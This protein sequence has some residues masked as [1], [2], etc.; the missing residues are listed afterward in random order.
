MHGWEKRSTIGETLP[1]PRG[2][3]HLKKKPCF[4]GSSSSKV[5][6]AVPV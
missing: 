3:G 2:L 6:V 1:L 4:S 5:K